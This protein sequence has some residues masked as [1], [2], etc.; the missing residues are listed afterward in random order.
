MA[1]DRKRLIKQRTASSSNKPW[2]NWDNL[3]FLLKSLLMSR[4]RWISP[5]T[6]GYPVIVRPAFTLGGSGGGIANTKEEL[7][8]IAHGGIQESPIGQILVER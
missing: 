1:L 2:K 4:Q 8:E 3:V 5:Q 6:I 7:E